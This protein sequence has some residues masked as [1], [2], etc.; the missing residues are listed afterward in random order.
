VCVEA[1]AD[2]VAAEADPV[3]VALGWALLRLRYLFD[4][5]VSVLAVVA[6]AVS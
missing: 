3:E 4:V 6:A 5:H 2:E 1:A